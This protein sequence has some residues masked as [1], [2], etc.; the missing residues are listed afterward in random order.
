MSFNLWTSRAKSPTYL[1]E[2]ALATT[3]STPFNMWRVALWIN[4]LSREI[5][6]VVNS[7]VMRLDTMFRLAPLESKKAAVSRSSGVVE[8]K[9]KDPVSSYRPTAI[10]VASS[11]VRGIFCSFRILARMVIVAPT[12]RVTSTVPWRSSGEGGW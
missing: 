5:W 10:T 3:T 6:S 4:S 1:L 7:R 9:V 2:E 11:A 12:S 8:E